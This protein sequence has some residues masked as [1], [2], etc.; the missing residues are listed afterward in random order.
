[1][2]L[3]PAFFVAVTLEPAFFVAVTLEPAFFVA[4]TLEGFFFGSL[5][6]SSLIVSG[7][8]P[9][10]FLRFL[11]SGFGARVGFVRPIAAALA[12]HGSAAP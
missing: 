6:R 12:F 3:E 4:M 11:A 10:F 8:R 5:R 9:S 1:V 2:T 7:G